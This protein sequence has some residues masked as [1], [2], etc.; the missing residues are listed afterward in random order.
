MTSRDEQRRKRRSD[1]F[2]RDEADEADDWLA[3][4][5][6]SSRGEPDP[7]E[8]AGPDPRDLDDHRFD[9]PAGAYD[10]PLE[11]PARMERSGEVRA[12]RTG[13]IREPRTGDVRGRRAADDSPSG[14]YTTGD[15]RGRRAA[16]D[17][18]SGV[19]TT[20]DIR[21]R[22]SAGDSPSGVFGPG[23]LP[24]APPPA[25]PANVDGWSAP[26]AS[27]TSTGRRRRAEDDSPGGAYRRSAD[28]SPSG[29]Y[30][31]SADDSPSGVYRRSAEDSPSGV[32]RRAADDSPSGVYRRSVDDSPGGAY[33]RSV[34]DSPGGA[35]RGA[36]ASPGA[37]RGADDSPSGVYGSPSGVY[38]RGPAT[39]P[40]AARP[41]LDQQLT[42][43]Q[44]PV[45]PPVDP[46]GSGGRRRA[47]EESSYD[48]GPP[49]TPIIK[50]LAELTAPAPT[51]EPP[52][53]VPI[54]P[55]MRPDA[56]PTSGAARRAR[57]AAEEQRANRT[58]DLGPRTGDLGPR[59][60][61]LR[62]RTGD[63]GPRTGDLG[64]RTGD[65][66][67]RTGDL[68]PRTGDLGARTGDVT[69]GRRR[70]PADEVEPGR[71]GPEGV[72]RGETAMF[73]P[74][75][76]T[77]SRSRRAATN[78]ASAS[79]TTMFR[80]G[81]RPRGNR[82]RAPYDD[83]PRAFESAAPPDTRRDD[84]GVRRREE[85][86]RRRPAYDE[87]PQQRRA[88]D[89]D[90]AYDPYDPYDE[91][92]EVRRGRGGRGT[93]EYTGDYT[94]GGT[95]RPARELRDRPDPDR[96]DRDLPRGRERIRE[97]DRPEPPD[98]LDRP[99]SN[100]MVVD[101]VRTGPRPHRWIAMLSVIAVLVVLSACG[102]G[103]WFILKDEKNGPDSAKSGQTSAPK[104]RDISSRAVDPKALTEAEVFPQ[105]SIVAVPNE[106]PYVIL[107]TKASNDCKV[108]A[109]EEL[110]TLL[111]GAGCTEVVRA[112]LK[113]PN[114]EYLITAGIFNVTSEQVAAKTFDGIK[115][116]VDG[117]KGRFAGMSVGAGTG[118]DALV[119]APTQLGWN[120]KGHFIT[121]CVIARVDGNNFAQGDPYPNQIT[122]D[123]VETYL[124]NGIIENR[125]II[126]PEAT[127]AASLPGAQPS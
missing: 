69:G 51:T 100:R 22:R 39:P 6:G 98:R 121:Y 120:Y 52:P 107:A 13:D 38:G 2:R 28:D 15:I 93:G 37:Y 119:R 77:G 31:R 32:S 63:L 95:R 66:G 64:S 12:A 56:S 53:L 25:R 68:G 71:S 91:P 70:A 33:R 101:P 49:L 73:R 8:P 78:G 21:G 44:V 4:L 80:P 43:P 97:L 30:R 110:A 79:E 81:E 65:L 26:D 86:A 83:D 19:Y 88:L 41:P 61:D 62:S 87:P 94:S 108:A 106:P 89:D 1:S 11:R 24:P 34:D 60:G 20:G 104:K 67:P 40:P 5:R 109:T 48:A 118:T 84:S 115:P 92:S 116:I 16:D 42:A 3:G 125:S 111:A 14:I 76:D 7:F 58:G 23:S 47:R 117:Q 90:I 46:P 35:Y 59:T 82:G 17:S 29:V 18:P 27:T 85:V 36:G 122:Y 57:R 113:S 72:Y 123:I 114:E 96:L 102:V 55:N 126:Q 74:V 50:P 54:F 103:T 127:P 112:T 124:D 9:G 45:S 75:D 10:R 99:R 105:N